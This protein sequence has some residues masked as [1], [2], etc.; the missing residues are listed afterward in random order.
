MFR[1]KMATPSSSFSKDMK[2]IHSLLSLCTSCRMSIAVKECIQG[3]EGRLYHRSCLLQMS[4][5]QNVVEGIDYYQDRN[6]LVSNRSE[7]NQ[8]ETSFDLLQQQYSG[9]FVQQESGK[10]FSMSDDDFIL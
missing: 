5:S 2:H 6:Y 4:F 10:L 1:R 3:P 8:M 7:K 9:A